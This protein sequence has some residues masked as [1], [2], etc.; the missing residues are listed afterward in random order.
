[1]EKRHRIFVAINLPGDIKRELFKYSEKW[2]EIEAKW[3]AK[4]N[5][6][7]TLEFLG[8]LTDQELGEVCMVVKDVA[9]MHQEFSLNLTK[10]VYGPEKLKPRQVPKF[11]WAT[12]ENSKELTKLKNNLQEV[13]LERIRFAPQE[14]LFAP[15]ITL[16]RIGT[17]AFRQFEQDEIPEINEGLDLFFTVES[18]EVMESELKRGGPVYTVLESHQLNP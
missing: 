8:A 16:A 11:I 15:H 3:T 5:L 10:I 4:D 2:P 13:L 7:I 12:G 9:K 17:F 18:I 1:M 6:H 14:R